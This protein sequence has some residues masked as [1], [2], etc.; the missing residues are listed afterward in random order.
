MANII[1]K[2]TNFSEGDT[3]TAT[4]LN[5]HVDNASFVSGTG[6]TTDNSSLEVHTDGYLKVK[7]GG[8][9]SSHLAD[10]AISGSSTVV[11]N[12][13]NFTDNTISGGKLVDDSISS[14][15][16]SMATDAYDGVKKQSSGIAFDP[17]FIRVFTTKVARMTTVCFDISFGVGGEYPLLSV[18][19]DSDNI[20]FLFEPPTGKTWNA[21]DLGSIT[22]A[23][24]GNH[25][26]YGSLRYE[27]FDDS[28]YGLSGYNQQSEGWITF[29]GGSDGECIYIF[30]SEAMAG[31]YLGRIHGSIT[32]PTAS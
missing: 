23:L 5:N 30:L 11:V 9:Q 19:T 29:E 6:N 14:D 26:P 31:K 12:N 2:G 1:S 25:Y 4:N 22:A 10:D 13:N 32:F 24:D 17:A 15:K 18:P 28:S 27:T 3:V 21:F 7:D 20:T 16:L 8:I